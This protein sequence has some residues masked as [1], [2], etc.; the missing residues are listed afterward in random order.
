[1]E[2]FLLLLFVPLLLLHWLSVEV[3]PL[4]MLCLQLN[5]LCRAL[6]AHG[7]KLQACRAL[8]ICSISLCSACGLVQTTLALNT[9]VFKT[10]FFAV[11]KWL[12]S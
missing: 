3:C 12:L 6:R 11:M 10:L 9:K 8:V 7:G 1:M 2:M 5:L 4:W